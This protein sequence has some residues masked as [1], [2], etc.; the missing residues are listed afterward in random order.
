[1]ARGEIISS[2]GNLGLHPR[3][4]N[5]LYCN[6]RHEP[7]TSA[8]KV[9]AF[10][11]RLEK[12]NEVFYPGGSVAIEG[13]RDVWRG[14]VE[15]RVAKDLIISSNNGNN[16]SKVETAF[17]IRENLWY[18]V[19]ARN[20]SERKYLRPLEEIVEGA[21]QNI[22][23]FNSPLEIIRKVI[24]EDY[25]FITTILPEDKK[26]KQELFQLWGET[27][28]WDLEQISNFCTR[29]STEDNENRT[30]WF[31]GIKN[32]DGKLIAAA[33]AELLLLKGHNGEDIEIV[34][35]TEWRSE[36][37]D[38]A[39]AVI[40]QLHVQVLHSYDDAI[41]IAECNYH[42]GAHRAAQKSGMISPD[43]FVND[44]QVSQVLEQNVTV[45]DG[46]SPKGLRDFVVYVLPKD[47]IPEKEREEIL[48]IT[49]P[50]TTYA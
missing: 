14:L 1:M 40:D 4:D 45:N 27:F 24:S 9:S 28:G 20:D 18:L 38:Y 23:P 19:A 47:A 13:R 6:W 17:P 3:G 7:I 34:E 31:S 41:I 29:L 11:R 5:R 15:E 25:S 21:R 39:K 8:L 33:M 49:D 12:I 30:V 32:T 42:R 2:T 26:T 46:N 50:N 36:K 43:V 10:F 48:R 22:R 37:K 35:S 44:M 16:S